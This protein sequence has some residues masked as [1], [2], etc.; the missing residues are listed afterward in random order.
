MA[1]VRESQRPS[2]LVNSCLAP[3]GSRPSAKGS[4]LG[5]S[6][7]WWASSGTRRRGRLGSCLHRND[8]RTRR[9]YVCY[10]NSR[11]M[12]RRLC[13]C[14]I[15]RWRDFSLINSL[16][17]PHAAKAR[18]AERQRGTGDASPWGSVHWNRRAGRRI[19][20]AIG[21][22]SSVSPRSLRL[23]DVR[24]KKTFVAASPEA[25]YRQVVPE[26]R[27]GPFY[28]IRIGERTAFRSR[29]QPN[30]DAARIAR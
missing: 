10:R 4:T 27:D 19:T 17:G 9:L 23:I 12:W 14:I 2:L 18:E 5:T 11:L 3:C 15:T 26:E 30:A 20:S 1:Q 7:C 29:R 22:T 16:N 24:T 28:L 13:G 21:S 25:A 8:S 6:C